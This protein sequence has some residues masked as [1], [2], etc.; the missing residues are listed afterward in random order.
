MRDSGI[1][2]LYL[3]QIASGD[4]D[5]SYYHTLLAGLALGL[6]ER[7]ERGHHLLMQIFEER[8]QKAGAQRKTGQSDGH[9][10]LSSE[11]KSR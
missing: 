4:E 5:V 11:M 1:Q 9:F 10:P 7:D 3:P 6:G 8:H 2:E